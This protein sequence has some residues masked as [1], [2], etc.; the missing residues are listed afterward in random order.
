MDSVSWDLAQS[1]WEDQ[2]SD[3]ENIISFDSGSTYYWKHD[4]ESLL[5]SEDYSSL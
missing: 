5:E 3:E 1:E 2:E 4:I